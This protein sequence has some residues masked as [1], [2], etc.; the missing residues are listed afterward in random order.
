MK[1]MQCEVCGSSEIKKISD[2]IFECQSCGVQYST[3]EVKKLLVEITGKVKIDHSEEVENNIKRAEQYAQAGN[4]AKA[5]EYYNAALD[6]DANNEIA[7]QRMKEIEDQQELEDYY[8]IE[9]DVDPQENVK[10]FFKQLASTQNI[11]CDIYKEIAIKSVTEKYMTFFF[12]KAKYQADWTAT[13]C[14]VYYE[15]QTVYK[16][17]YDS[18]LKRRVKEPVTEKVERVNRVPQSGSH[19]FTSQELVLASNNLG[20]LFTVET[21]AVKRDLISA[22]ETQQDEKYGTYD[23]HKINPR[24]VQKTDGQF[25][26]KNLALDLYTSSSVY[27]DKKKKMAERATE[28]VAP[29]ITSSIGGD[30]YENLNATRHTLSESVVCVCIPVQ[31]IE[32]TYKGK[33]YAALS[34]LLS[35]TSTMPL[36]YP[37][38]SELATALEGLETQK[39]VSQKMPC[40]KGGLITACI[41]FVVLFLGIFLGEEDVFIPVSLIFIGIGLILMLIGMIISRIRTARFRENATNVKQVLFD[42]RVAALEETQKQFFDEYTDYASAQ[43]AASGAIC[44]AIKQTK[45]TLSEAGVIRKK[46]AYVTNDVDSDNTIETLEAGIKLLKKKRTIGILASLVIGAMLGILGCMLLSELRYIHTLANVILWIVTI[47]S[48]LSAA[49]GFGITMGIRNAQIRK[50][51][52]AIYTYKMRKHLNEEFESPQENA[53]AQLLAWSEERIDEAVEK[54]NA[55]TDTSVPKK[56]R[57]RNWAKQNKLL[58]TIAG[59]IALL[60][61]LI[62]I[63]EAVVCGVTAISYD[64]E[65]VG[66]TFEYRWDSYGGKTA[67]ISTY[68]F[69]ANNKVEKTFKEINHATDRVTYEYTYILDYSVHYDMASGTLRLIIGF[70][71]GN[72]Y[73]S[74]DE[75]SIVCIEIFGDAYDLVEESKGNKAPSTTPTSAPTTPTTQTSTQKPTQAPT[76][77]PTQKPTAAPTPCSHTYKDATCTAPKTCTKC[78]ATSGSALPHTW[79]AATCTEPETC[80]VCGAT[81]TPALGHNYSAATCITPATC[82]DCGATSGDVAEH[83]WKEATCTA[84]ATCSVCNKTSGRARGHIM[85]GTVCEECNHTDFSAFAGTF[86][87]VNDVGCECFEAGCMPTK[88]SLSKDGVLSFTFEGEAYSVTLEQDR[89]DHDF[90]EVIFSFDAYLNGVKDEEDYLYADITVDQ[91][92]ME[93]TL[94][95]WWDFFCFYDESRD[96]YIEDLYFDVVGTL[97]VLPYTE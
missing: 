37:C 21:D 19:I 8:I 34:D 79:K 63:V 87:K 54:I 33:N 40:M 64:R 46:M 71:S 61:L 96:I 44:L 25:I 50:L 93:F 14:H 45:P 83:R 9:P 97:D 82:S 35:Y 73:F 23:V 86:S 16:E 32:Y 12:M 74:D 76:Q 80:T 60:L 88:V 59:G 43:N 81:D 92:G 6:M 22:F 68:R 7:Q 10:H 95:F 29:E 18:T 15:N 4:T 38:D 77:A 52:G 67:S 47:G 30:Y 42:P 89:S 56:E 48:F 90:D 31:I 66:K 28:R 55:A 36:I 13:A 3:S 24:D 39:E 72:L 65:L 91:D 70:S 78:G 85:D 27:S 62:V 51:R 11:A 17:R 75:S 53:S 58:L 26:Y 41:G 94:S 57:L 1:K 84:P 20:S 69:I 5:A 2:G 49:V